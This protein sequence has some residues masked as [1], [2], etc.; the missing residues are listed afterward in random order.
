MGSIGKSIRCK[1]LANLNVVGNVSL[2][3]SQLNISKT[4]NQSNKTQLQGQSPY[5]INS[6]LY[7]QND[8]SGLQVSLLYNV[9]GPRIFLLGTLQYPNIGELSRHTIDITVSQRLNKR[10]SLNIGAQDILNNPVFLVQDTNN[11]GHFSRNGSDKLI[12]KFRR[13]PYYTF[14][15]K[16]IL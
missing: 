12:M 11:D 2:I 5:I 3:Q 6:G 9:F 16:F 8:S 13:G 10:F 15:V 7:Y 1:Q 14:G 4:I